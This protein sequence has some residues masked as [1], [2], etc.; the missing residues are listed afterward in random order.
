VKRA[1]ICKM[2]AIVAATAAVAFA[3]VAVA[4]ALSTRPYVPDPVEFE[5]PAP[6][7]GAGSTAS[8]S[9]AR[10]VVSPVIR[11][12][13]RFDLFGLRWRGAKLSS[14]AVRVRGA[15][16]WSRWTSVPVDP[17]HAP[18]AGS[19]E[20]RGP[21]KASDPVWA[22]GSDELQYRLRARGPVRN[23]RLHFVNTK[24]T[25]TA[26]DRLRSKLRRAANAT[27]TAVGSLL[28]AGRAHAADGAPP[29]VGRDAWGASKCP[30]R[31]LPSYGTVNLAFIHHTV[32]ANDYGPG[33]SAAMVLGIC[34]YHRNSNGWNDIGYNFVVDKYG[35]IF[36]G[37]AGGVDAPV[38]G[39]QAQGYN[40]RSTGIANLGTFSTTGQTEAGLQA[41]TRLVAWKL[42]VHGV[43]P[44]G[45]VTLTSN[46]GASNR[47]PAGASVTFQRVSGHRDADA[48]SCPGDALYAQLPRLREM[49]AQTPLAPA[50]KLVLEAAS[51]NITFGSKA[52]LRASLSAPDG[53]PLGGRQLELQV[54]GRRGW[55]TMQSL[56]SDAS[57]VLST[58]LR[59]TYNHAVRARFAGETGLQEIRSR[60]ISIGVRPLVQARLGPSTSATLEPGGRVTI[61]GK[62]RP[63]KS[64]ALLV[65]NR[66]TPAGRGLRVGRRIVRVRSGAVRV[67]LRF[68]RS[69]SYTIRLAVFGDRMNLAARSRPLAVKVR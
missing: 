25:A 20:R 50:P 53:T 37:R 3:L 15:G 35:Q 39:A 7:P 5:L 64:T 59:L 16:D 58:K 33:D 21:W 18:D 9:H 45:T 4:P 67:R 52:S 30:P 1:L 42:G 2:V 48:T 22:G 19:A 36:E 10:R 54:L 28:G 43:P 34:L 27:V 24:G 32:S 62:V 13:K 23:L 66:I 40:S 51:G 57:G 55:N 60:P 12:P 26:L 49:V 29:I 56:R 14:L 6:V 44:T 41:L 61:S 17:D 8:T 11:S 69:G 47:Y 68:T 46:G 63:H 65:V 31:A 38:V